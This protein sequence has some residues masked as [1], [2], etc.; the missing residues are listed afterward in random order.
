MVARSARVPIS[1]RAAMR[2]ASSSRR[3]T[4]ASSG[5]ASGWMLPW[6]S[7]LSSMRLPL[8]GVTRV[9]R[10]VSGCAGVC[11]VQIATNG[12]HGLSG[13]G[14]RDALRQLQRAGLCPDG[15]GGLAM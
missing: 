4:K 3:T 15:E 9:G 5:T 12:G 13:E 11:G 14:G 6:R 10:V 7:V 2:A 8:D 1:S